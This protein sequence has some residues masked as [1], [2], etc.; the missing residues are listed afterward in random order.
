MF[1]I[2]KSFLCLIL[3]FTIIGCINKNQANKRGEYISKMKDNIKIGVA[4]PLEDYAETFINGIEL[5]LNDINQSNILNNKKIEIIYKNDKSSVT[6]GV[7]IANEF[8]LDIS[9][10]AVIGHRNSYISVQTAPIYE[11][12]GI[13]HITPGSTSPTL[14]MRNYQYFLRTIPSDIEIGKQAADYAKAQNYK[15][16][17]IYYEKNDYGRALANSFED[18]AYKNNIFIVDRRSIISGSDKEFREEVEY[19]KLMDF[20]AFFLATV[21]PAAPDFIKFARNE[22]FE[23]PVIGGDGLD[24]D[25][26]I[27]IGGKCVENTV[28]LSVYNPKDNSKK[29]IDFK[30]NYKK[31]YGNYPDMWAAQA[32]DTLNLLAY[33]IKKADSPEPLKIIQ[34]IKNSPKWLGVT[35]NHSFD[36][37]GEISD[38]KVVIKKV[39]NGKFEF[40]NEGE[41]KDE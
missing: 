39:V 11:N 9:I 10:S 13:L 29:N 14:T 17:V 21:M 38:K 18:Q 8:A 35:G 41:S 33:G 2:I 12:A 37:N 7:E 15:K 24:H 32:Y 31:K 20:D 22:G 30:N 40:V 3:I 23:N 28:A 25:D 4:W 36:K 26:L 6:G 5:A 19:W 27:R 16:I 34:A 1:K